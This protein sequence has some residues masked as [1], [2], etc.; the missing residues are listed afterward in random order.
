MSFTFYFCYGENGGFR[1]EWKKKTKRIVL[2]KIVFGYQ[3][4]D[5]EVFTMRLIKR[6]KDIT[7]ILKK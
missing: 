4:R 5:M 1:I 7:E 6:L 2:W 3:G